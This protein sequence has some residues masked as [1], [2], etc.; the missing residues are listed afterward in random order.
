[1]KRPLL[2]LLFTFFLIPLLNGIEFSAKEKAIIYT[3]S[4]KVLQ[5]YETVINQI[6]V[7]VVTDIEKA[8][9]SSE[10]LLEL[11]V[12]RQVLVYND[13]DP[14]HKL[15]EFYEAETYSNN[16]V[17]WYPDGIS[18]TLDLV[19]ARV[20]EII[21][22]EENVYS[23]DILVRKSIN[24]NYLNQTLNKNTEELTFRIAFNLEKNSPGK[25]RIVG[26]RSAASNFLIDYSQA[27]KEVNNEDFNSED[28]V[29]IHSEIKMVLQ[30]YAN[31]LSLIGDPQESTED[32]SFYK[33]SFLKLF[34]GTDNRVYN[35]I[36]PDPQTKLIPVTD[37]LT[38]YIADFPNG[39]KNLS[40]NADSA[41]FGKVMKAEDGS[42]YTYTDANKF[43]SGNY[44][45]KDVFREMFPLIFKI[46]FTAAGKTFSDF[47]ITGIDISSANFYEAT[48]GAANMAKPEIVIKPVTRK[49]LGLSFSGSFGKT[50]IIDNNIESLTM[51]KNFHSWNVTPL[52]G[53]AGA[54]GITYNFTDNI[55]FRSGLELSK[56]SERFNLS[57]KFTDKVLS[58]DINGDSYYRIIEAE[59][60][61]VVNIN[62][63]SLPLVINYTSGKPGQ[64]GFYAEGG[65]KI[66]IPTKVVYKDS[67]NYQFYAS[68]YSNFI[69]A[70]DALLAPELGFY[71][72][73]NID[74]TG[75]VNLKG[76]SLAFYASAGVNI[77]V[78]YYSSFQIGPE[79]NF[80]IS[81]IMG[82]EETYKD[83]F[84]KPYPHQP[85]K[86]K[87]FGLKISFVYKL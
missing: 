20:S 38:T 9:S 12:N 30:D 1:M 83:I 57:G 19:N 66:S 34:P 49:G 37:Y 86:I 71:S 82:K 56:Y 70:K 39:I 62:F 6:G 27:L 47:R 60:D 22:H 31:F 35:D 75:N 72:R 16:I 5:T 41:K 24:G 58:T 73:E 14:A 25:F 85:V 52:F 50:S 7:S 87:N 74:E 23:I 64:L 79:I 33:D 81:D 46:S 80:G 55:S 13:L 48:P 84:H 76:I 68:P 28:L 21:S 78:G 69:E 17:L 3:N 26:I 51:D 67:G 11:F 15:S 45:G 18:I 77:P 8:K 4:I 54:V 61:S 63:I 29:K 42:Y 59:Y 36:M 44:K 40:I 43:F 65:V 53:F 2:L 10:S 32:K